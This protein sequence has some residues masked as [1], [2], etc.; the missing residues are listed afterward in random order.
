MIDLNIKG[1]Y[2]AIK[3]I[4]NTPV[5]PLKHPKGS[6][7][8]LKL[9]YKNPTGSHK[10]RIAAYMLL[11]A[12]KKGLFDKCSTIVEASS[13]N[14]GIA[15]ATLARVLGLKPVIVI[16]RDASEEAKRLLKITEADIVEASHSENIIEKAREIA[17]RNNWVFLNQFENEANIRAHYETTGPEIWS[18]T[19]GRIDVFIMGIGTGGTITGV[20]R[21]I[22]NM[23]KSVRVI[24]VVPKGSPVTGG[25]GSLEGI[26]GLAGSE[27]PPL[28]DSNVV[29]EI[30]EV[31][32]RDAVDMV[33]EIGR[34]YG[35]L[36][37][38]STGAMLNI[39]FKIADESNKKINIVT[40][41]ADSIHKYTSIIT[42]V[43][44]LK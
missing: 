23:N 17:E 29:D 18:Q 5:I 40:L 41:A 8:W 22:K 14:T 27:A 43:V 11:D 20:G 33:L 30:Y 16:S 36:V 44:N 12:I 37:G 15:V 25:S 21:F 34:L 35:V 31:T 32:L 7:I 19:R 3:Y 26:P 2:N 39:A 10:D 4:G 38:L 28:L 1:F 13:G 24:G 9:E 42:R 6:R